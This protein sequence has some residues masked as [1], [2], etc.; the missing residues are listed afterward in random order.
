MPESG[1]TWAK[2]GEEWP[3]VPFVVGKADDQTR[4]TP[5]KVGCGN[6]LMENSIVYFFLL[7]YTISVTLKYH[8][9]MCFQTYVGT[10][11]IF[12]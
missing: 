8:H 11:K 7:N 6:W 1:L 9:I 12:T 4:Y 2:H 3:M 10:L 5:Y